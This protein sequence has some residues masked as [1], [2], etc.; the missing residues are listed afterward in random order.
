MLCPAETPYKLPD[1]PE[2]SSHLIPVFNRQPLSF[3]TG[4]G[5][6]LMDTQGRRYLDALSGIAVCGM[7]HAHPKICDAVNQQVNRLWHTSNLYSI[8]WQH[9]AG[10]KLCAFSGMDQ[11]FYANSGAEANEAAL[12]LARRRAHDQ[13]KTRPKVIVMEGAFHGRTLLTLS[14]TANAGVRDGFYPLDNDFV[15][16]PFG[17]TQAIQQICEQDTDICAVFLEPIQGEGGIRFAPQGLKFLEEVA[18]I[19]EQYDLLFMLDEIQTGN[20]RTGKPYAYQHTSVKPDV[21]TTAKGLAN[22]FPAGACLVSNKALGVF[23]VGA[24]GSTYGGTPLQCCAI[25]ATL[26]AIEEEQAVQNAHDIGQWMKD[27]FQARLPADCM[28][29]GLGLMIGV[30]LPVNCA[31]LVN[32]A[33][34]EHHLLLNVTAGKVIRLLPPLITNHEQ[35][36][37]IVSS[38]CQMVIK[39]LDNA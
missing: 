12:K 22:G 8:E 36:E 21:L 25:H 30:E 4:Q 2:P 33:R 13:G 24:H 10:K 11:V 6:W 32:T 26:S 17:D 28:V 37:Q 31:E 15:R 39:F 14:A 35:A 34:D 1:M 3:Q 29:R 7:G 18:Q 38:V 19:C 20:G 5:V 9:L 16:V 23:G 27:Q